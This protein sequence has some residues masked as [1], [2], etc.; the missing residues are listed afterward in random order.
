MQDGGTYLEKPPVR[1]GLFKNMNK[2]EQNAPGTKF[3]T[4]HFLRN[5]QWAQ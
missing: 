3:T 4:L 5:L 2:C 1:F